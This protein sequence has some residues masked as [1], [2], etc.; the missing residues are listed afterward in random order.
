ML[1]TKQRKKKNNRKLAWETMW[2]FEQIQYSVKEKQ[3][4]ERKDTV[5]LFPDIMMNI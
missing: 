5:C 2:P 1:W 4:M 3:Q